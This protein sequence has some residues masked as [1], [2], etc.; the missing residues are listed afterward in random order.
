MR[1]AEDGCD[2]VS[3]DQIGN[4]DSSAH[5]GEAYPRRRHPPYGSQV[6]VRSAS[7]LTPVSAK[8]APAVLAHPEAWPRP[9]EEVPTME[10]YGTAERLSPGSGLRSLDPVPR[11]PTPGSAVDPAVVDVVLSRLADL[12]VQRLMERIADAKQSVVEW[13]DAR[14]AADYLGIHR[15]TLRKLAAERA[16]P[17]HQDGPGCKL[18]F[19]RDELDEWRRSSRD[20][21]SRL[22]AVS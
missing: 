18:Y 22:R 16:V 12:V 8:M 2:V 11:A 9:N 17:V 10:A 19:R 6:S 5:N 13:L 15:D 4:I 20:G 21:R 7:Y 1:E 14:G 3:V